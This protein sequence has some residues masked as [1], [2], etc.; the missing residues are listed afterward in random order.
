MENLYMKRCKPILIALVAL[1]SVVAAASDTRPPPLDVFAVNSATPAAPARSAQAVPSAHRPRSS[2]GTKANLANFGG[3]VVKDMRAASDFVQER[4]A[5]AITPN[6]WLIALSAFGLVAL[7]LRR[8]HKSLP[9][10][11]IST[12]S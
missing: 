5:E 1:F 2:S 11:R 4:A 3:D 9:Q 7:Q 12:Y 10:R 8:K 6:P